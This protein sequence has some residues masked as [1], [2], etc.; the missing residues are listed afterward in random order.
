MFAPS[1]PPPGPSRMIVSPTETELAPLS[2]PYA[3]EARVTEF[4][5]MPVAEVEVH[6]YLLFWVLL[7]AEKS[8]PVNLRKQTTQ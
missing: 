7:V 3:V 8:P 1:F 2:D 4:D 5:V 6:V